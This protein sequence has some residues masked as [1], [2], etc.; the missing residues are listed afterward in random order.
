MPQILGTMYFRACFHLFD[1]L[2]NILVVFHMGAYVLP[3]MWILAFGVFFV[4]VVVSLLLCHSKA[5]AGPLNNVPLKCLIEMFC[6][7]CMLLRPEK[8]HFPVVLDVL[9]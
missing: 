5:I 1:V 3:D 9:V 2:S 4:V 8:F 6:D 7:V